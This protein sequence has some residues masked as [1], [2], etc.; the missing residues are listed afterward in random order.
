MKGREDQDDEPAASARIIPTIGNMPRGETDGR[1]K[2]KDEMSLM[3]FGAYH[4]W[5]YGEIMTTAP[6]YATH[7]CHESIERSPEQQQFQEWIPLKAYDDENEA[8]KWQNPKH[9]TK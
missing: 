3:N 6:N 4:D 8:W 7:I 9:P 2:V 5:A 1:A